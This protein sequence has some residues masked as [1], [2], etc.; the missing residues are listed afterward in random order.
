[1]RGCK[2]WTMDIRAVARFLR[3]W[4]VCIALIAGFVLSFPARAQDAP[5][6][7]KGR[8]TDSSGAAIDAAD[9]TLTLTASDV[10]QTAKTSSKGEYVFSQLTPGIYSIHISHPKF[11][12][13]DREGVT[14]KTGQTVRLDITLKAPDAGKPGATVASA[15]DSNLMYRPGYC[16]GLT[17]VAS[18]DVPGFAAMR[19]RATG[20]R[21]P[22]RFHRQSLYS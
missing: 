4:P 15:V 8:I 6:Q 7:V 20:R 1:M 21:Q 16:R 14:V 17:R 2:F 9:V 3:V 10:S 12:P 5:G 19:R 11:A 13:L 18:G 22:W